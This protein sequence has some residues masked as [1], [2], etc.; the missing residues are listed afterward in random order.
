MFARI[1]KKPPMDELTCGIIPAP[2]MED[3]FHLS[4][5]EYHLPEENIAQ[6][7]C[8]QRDQ[9]RLLLLD[10]ENDTRTHGRFSDIIDCFLPG[11]ILVVNDTRVFPA[12]LQG[13]KE[14]GGRVEALL[15][16]FPETIL[17]RSLPDDWSAVRAEALV[18]SSK[19]PRPRSRLIFS[20][21]LEAVVLELHQ[22][23]RVSLDLRYA[24]KA[25][26]TLEDLLKEYGQMPL[27]PYIKRPAGST[28]DDL[29][30]YQTSYARETG[31]VAAPTAGLHFTEELLE[32]LEKRGVVIVTVTLHVGY[33]T[34]APVRTEDI[35]EH[36]IHTEYVNIPPET[37]ETINDYKKYGSRIWAVGTT[38]TRALEYTAHLNGEISP[39]S[40]LC[41]MYIY[42]GYRFRVVDNL[43]TNFHLPGSSLLFLVSALAGRE[44]ILAAYAEAVSRGYRFFS[45]G[46]AMA[47]V[48]RPRPGADR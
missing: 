8:D 35:R 17:A 46:D 29:R 2:L 11:D 6:H 47:I 5:Y 42:P 3:I 41:D 33:G 25:G 38:S 37:A 30:R 32:R 9:S 19:R 26:Q 44:R 12:R 22:G 48:T 24:L 18:K 27:P 40:G 21:R 13:R 15:L 28:D 34:F 39:Y 43:I 10:C 36:R 45:Y 16:A 4:A 20:D 1:L 31:S 14:S 23:G 7:P